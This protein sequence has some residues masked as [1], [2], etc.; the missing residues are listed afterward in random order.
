MPAPGFVAFASCP[1]CQPA[2]EFLDG[3]ECRGPNAC[4]GFRIRAAIKD[5]EEHK[6]RI[7][8][9]MRG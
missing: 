2:I 4:I 7:N 8:L 5:K 6:N 1:L 9:L 3:V